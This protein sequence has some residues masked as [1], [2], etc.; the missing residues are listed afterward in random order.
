MEL[1]DRFALI[2]LLFELPDFSTVDRRTTLL[3]VLEL[4]AFGQRLQED[5]KSAAQELVLRLLKAEERPH[6]MRRLLDYILVL[7]E[8]NKDAAACVTRLITTYDFLRKDG[9]TIPGIE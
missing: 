1:Q 5:K 9:E 3:G 2:K 8:D 7:A 4:E 6:P